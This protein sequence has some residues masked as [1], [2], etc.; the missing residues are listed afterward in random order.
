[1]S[2]GEVVDFDNHLW[3]LKDLK[4]D[5]AWL[6]LFIVYFEQYNYFIIEL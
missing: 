1:M 5:F 4:E 3:T 2:V 6:S